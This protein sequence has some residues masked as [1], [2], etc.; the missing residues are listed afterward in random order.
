MVRVVDGGN[1]SDGVVKVDLVKNIWRW[2]WRCENA[3]GKRRNGESRELHNDM[4][5]ERRCKKGVIL[6]RASD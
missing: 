2:D 3:G 4:K 5:K 1:V 6:A